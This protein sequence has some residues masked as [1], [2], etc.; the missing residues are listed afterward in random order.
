MKYPGL[1]LF[2]ILAL[3]FAFAQQLMDITGTVMDQTQAV[4]PG[5]KVELQDATGKTVKATVS[6]PLGRFVVPEVL[7]GEYTLIVHLNGFQSQ[8]QRVI[9][10][11][12]KPIMASVEL[13][14]AGSSHV[15]NVVAEAAY[16]ESQAYTA[17]K[18]NIPL[19][20]VPQAIEVVNSELIR[21]QAAVSMQDAVRNVSGVSVHM[22]E[23][24]RDQILIR[25]F[26]A[27]NDY[28]V[29][30]V[31]DDAPYYR[32]LSTLDRI[33]VLKGP[34]AVLYGR[35]SSGG[36]VNRVTKTPEAEQPLMGELTTMVGGYGMKR[37]SGDTGLSF[38][39]GKAAVRLPGAWESSGSHR[40]D[41]YVD[42]FTFAPSLLWKISDNTKFVAQ[43]DYLNDD[44]LPDR[45]IPSINGRPANIDI[46]SYYGYAPD[47]F[48]DNQAF[49][50]WI[51]LEH[52]M[53]TWLV[54]NNFRH[55]NYDSAYSNTYSNGI[56]ETGGETFVKR[57]QYNFSGTQRNYFN[58]T[59]AVKFTRIAGMNHTILMGAEYGWQDRD[60]IRFTGTAGNVAL[61]NP[62]LTRPNYSTTP[63]TD[64]IFTGTVWAAYIQD[65]IDIAPKWK[66][67]VGARFDY[68]RQR[69]DDRR[70]ANADL[71]RID[72][73]VSPRVGLVYQ[74]IKWA[75]V[76]GSFSR[77]FQPSG[78]ALS[79]ATD[80]SEL[81]PETTRNYEGGVKFETLG[82]RLTSTVSAFHL[83]RNNI[84]TT[85]PLDPTKLVL[86]GE[87]R[88]NGMELSFS[89]RVVRN[90][91][92]YGGYA[93]LDAKILKSNSLSSGVLIQGKRPGQVPLHSGS[94]WATYRFQ[95]GFGFGTGVI[96]NADRFVANDDLVLLPGYTRVDATVSYR[97]S[98]YEI[99]LNL[100][101]VGNIKYYES[102]HANYNIYP[103]SPISG[104]LTTRVRW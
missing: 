66:A 88:T 46:G 85:D 12:G 59:E 44:R 49:S 69:L 25:G 100:R 36:I 87:Q 86:S 60:G 80:N 27:V 56:L 11:E 102:A 78:E 14:A 68:Y 99:A 94:L 20:D 19:R 1:V 83:I 71:G 96:Y 51:N 6:D 90:L 92:I 32:D 73:E 16:S 33:E 91:E 41:F 104:V 58:Q 89:G 23:G 37:V 53:G 8:Q 93:W 65:Q 3:P 48:L 18:T 4:V 5:A 17:T 22:G 95:N 40:H 70:P 98:R 62:V 13:Q 47:D 21:S 84:K 64:N 31:R 43:I 81:K 29:N 57:A 35:G 76:Y 15:V 10:A 82:G 101:N 2:L 77:S 39:G 72:R 52:R 7:A 61:I 67:T 42:R 75:S 38:L 30:G 54:R 97:K 34:A 74:P 50:Q 28:Y 63:A 55:T 26:S 103:G 24:R 45:G 79:L 9:V